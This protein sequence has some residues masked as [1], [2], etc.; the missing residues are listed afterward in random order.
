MPFEAFASSSMTRRSIY[1]GS[2][3]LCE[4]LSA[5]FMDGCSPEE[6]GV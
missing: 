5:D 4:H 6:G 1:V 3:Q 2:Q